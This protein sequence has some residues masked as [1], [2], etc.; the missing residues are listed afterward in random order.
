MFFNGNNKIRANG[1]IVALMKDCGD[2]SFDFSN[3]A[4]SERKPAISGNELE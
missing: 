2:F 1:L 4:L 3:E